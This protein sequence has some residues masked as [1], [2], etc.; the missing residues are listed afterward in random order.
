MREDIEN[1]KFNELTELERREYVAVLTYNIRRLCL[2]LI[3][4]GDNQL[5]G[6][7]SIATTIAM[8]DANKFNDL[9]Q[10]TH[11]L[12]QTIVIEQEIT[13]RAQA[14]AGTPEQ[15]EVKDDFPPLD[16]DKEQ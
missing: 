5:A 13:R 4:S 7:I 11:K 6:L 3:N 1:L 8:T 16:S 9:T 15:T 10:Y 14:A 2:Q 12:Y